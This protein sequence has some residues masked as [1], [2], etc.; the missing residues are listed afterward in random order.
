[1][2]FTIGAQRDD[3]VVEDNFKS[4]RLFF[5]LLPLLHLSQKIH[6]SFKHTVC[7]PLEVYKPYIYT[8]FLHNLGIK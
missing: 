5:S 3:S 8:E 6:N 2:I 7:P 1:M 4:V